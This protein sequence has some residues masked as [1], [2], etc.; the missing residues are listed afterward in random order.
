MLYNLD[1]YKKKSCLVIRFYFHNADGYWFNKLLR[2][3]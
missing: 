2:T 1:I 3:N